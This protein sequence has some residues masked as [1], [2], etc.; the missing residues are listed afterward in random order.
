M[1]GL[2]PIDMHGG[3]RACGI[4]NPTSRLRPSGKGV[5][6]GRRGDEGNVC[7]VGIRTVEG[8]DRSAGSGGGSQRIV[9]G[10]EGCGGA[11]DPGDGYVGVLGIKICDTWPG[12]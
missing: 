10:G 9:D 3:G 4:G 11:L 8:V 7:V 5:A 6:S 12:P 1:Y 2:V